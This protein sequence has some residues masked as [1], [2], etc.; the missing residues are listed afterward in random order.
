MAH[1]SAVAAASELPIVM[2]NVPEANKVNIGTELTKRLAGIPK[3]IGI[4]DSTSDF[5]YFQELLAAF[6]G[7]PFRLI[8][9]Q[10]T[11]VGASF[12]LGAH[13]AI[14]GASNIVPALSVQ[15]Y[16]AGIAGNIQETS[17]LQAQLMSVF[18]LLE[19]EETDPVSGSYYR[20]T[21]AS[22]MAGFECCLDILGL[23]KKVTTTPYSG[24]EPAL[25]ERAKHSRG[26]WYPT[27][28]DH[29]PVN[30]E[31][32]QGNIENKI[33]SRIDEL[34]ARHTPDELSAAARETFA[35][36]THYWTP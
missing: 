6:A 10:E 26:C 20:I 8:Q 21:V 34:L 27:I 5:V 22:Y 30:S 9:G 13:G 25:Y 17:K 35:S 33:Q 36:F 12:L 24:P 7:S 15:L 11:L 1:Y 23:C 2:Y 14:F 31:M 18:G 19:R 3:V 32:R 16:E 28:F 4:K 29:N